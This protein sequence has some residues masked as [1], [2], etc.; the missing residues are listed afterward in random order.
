MTTTM[1]ERL[2]EVAAND[3]DRALLLTGA[4]TAEVRAAYGRAVARIQAAHP[5]MPARLREWFA[6]ERMD[7]SMVADWLRAIVG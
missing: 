4:K 7:R 1:F 6:G 2:A 3:S 5:Q